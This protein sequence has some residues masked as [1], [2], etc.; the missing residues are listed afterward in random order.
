MGQ[1]RFPRTPGFLSQSQA[2][3]LQGCHLA[4]VSVSLPADPPA[5]VPPACRLVCSLQTAAQEGLLKCKAS[6]VI[7]LLETLYMALRGS[8]GT[9]GPALPPSLLSF[10]TFVTDG[11]PSSHASILQASPRLLKAVHAA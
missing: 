7:L 10:L 1:A 5:A 11:L 8:S 4:G 9:V 2:C 3:S 6:C